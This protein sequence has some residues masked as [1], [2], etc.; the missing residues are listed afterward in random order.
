MNKPRDFKGIYIK[1][2]SQNLIKI[3]INLYGGRNIPT[4]K[5]IE[6]HLRTHIGSI[7]TWKPKYFIG[8]TIDGQEIL[9]G[10]PKDP[11]D[12]E[13]QEGQPLEPSTLH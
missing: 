9:V 8:E 4:T 13:I 5:S 10:S 2:S 6:R 12:E 1:M 11:I 7:S 3:P